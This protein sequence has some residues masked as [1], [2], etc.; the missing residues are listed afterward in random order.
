MEFSADIPKNGVLSTIALEKACQGHEFKV[1]EQFRDKS[2]VQLRGV[3]AELEM[4]H[5]MLGFFG[6]VPAMLSCCQT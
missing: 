3:R 6:I 2:I 1:V 4:F 5:E